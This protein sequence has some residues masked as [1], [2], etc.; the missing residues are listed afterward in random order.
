MQIF[1]CDLPLPPRKVLSKALLIMKLTIILLFALCIQVSARVHAQEVSLSVKNSTL[2]QVFNQIKK[3]TGYSFLWDEGVLR[4]AKTVS[5]TV[6]GAS[7]EEVMNEC[8]RDQPL[9][10]TIDK[11]L[12]VVKA[13]AVE[14]KISDVIPE[15]PPADISLS[16]RVTNAKKEPLDG[17]S[18]T[19]KG[20]QI[21]TTTN[22]DGRF[23]LSVPSANVELVFSFVGYATQTVK[24]GSRTVFEIVLEEM[25]SDLSD[26]VVVGYGTQKKVNLT[27]AVSSVDYSKEAGSRPL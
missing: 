3:Q 4:K 2:K 15:P 20:T 9:T 22:A 14:T 21:G 13:A 6:K 1:F 24:A 19:V 8:L 18:V 7:I 17:V 27:G 16:G 5:F 12:I 23:L 11:R 10:Y 26:V 25:V